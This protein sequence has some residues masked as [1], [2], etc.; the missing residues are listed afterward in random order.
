MLSARVVGL[1]LPLPL[2]SLC[3]APLPV[4]LCV[5]LLALCPV[6][7]RRP[8]RGFQ[9]RQGG[10]QQWCRVHHPARGRIGSDDGHADLTRRPSDAPVCTSRGCEGVTGVDSSPAYT[11]QWREQVVSVNGRE[12]G[13]VMMNA[14]VVCS[15]DAGGEVDS[16]ALPAAV[17]HARAVSLCCIAGR[18]WQR[19][20]WELCGRVEGAEDAS[21]WRHLWAAVLL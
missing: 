3:L 14:A 20:R 16:K 13:M 18:L 19:W 2:P 11:R 1:C 10:R 9:R 12:D 15:G 17:G 7:R 21:R 4:L 8:G 5:C 6:Q